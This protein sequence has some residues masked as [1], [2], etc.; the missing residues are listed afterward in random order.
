[1]TTKSFTIE[2]VFGDKTVSKTGTCQVVETDGDVLQLL[3]EDASAVIPADAS[4]AETKRI[5]QRTISLVNY[6]LDLKAR[7][8]VTAQINSE[9]VDP[10]K[11][12]DKAVEQFMKMRAALGKPVTLE[13]AKAMLLAA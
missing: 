1:M 6:A 13:A 7:A 9:N 3:Q 8:K 5:R 10:D 12:V 11:A 4:E 2:K